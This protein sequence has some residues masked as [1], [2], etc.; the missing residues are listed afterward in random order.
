[1]RATPSPITLNTPIAAIDVG[2]NTVH[3]T[4]ARP[5][6]IVT[7]PTALEVIG[8]Q[9]DLVRLGH[10]I[11]VSGRISPER[12]DKAIAAL[13][14][15]VA[16]AHMLS[17]RTVLGIATQGVRAAENSAEF[18]TR[19]QAEIGIVL[20]VI[21]GAQEAALSYWGAT[22]DEPVGPG[23]HGV[24]DLGGG[25]L[26][27][28][29][30]E[31]TRVVWRVSLPLGAGTVRDHLALGDPPTVARLD[32]AFQVVREELR[33]LDLPHT[34]H[35]VAVCGGTAGALAALGARLFG[36]SRTRVAIRHGHLVEVT[37]RPILTR[38]HLE[39]VLGVL[40]KQPAGKIAARHNLKP[41]R[42][43]LLA[44]GAL[45]LL[46]TMERMGV[47]RLAVSRRGI[48]EGAILGY[49]HAGE[50]W[51]EAATRGTLS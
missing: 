50:A 46:A 42:A 2:S 10:D 21:T 17:A 32:R 5:S 9:S 19:A 51:L 4:V 41:A 18:I 34:P 1:V 23:L 48:R 22:S 49:V 44:A 7:R 33:P 16:F 6:D 43:R 13:A 3:V 26:E 20:Q 40:T 27:L 36:E 31:G 47:S 37:A 25:S 15:Y 45:V 24:V 8:D 35:E 30:G 28:V 39:T 14:Q 38:Y 29:V 12:A 11:A